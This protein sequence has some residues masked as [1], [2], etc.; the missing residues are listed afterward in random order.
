VFLRVVGV[1]HMKICTTLGRIGRT[2][3]IPANVM[4]VKMLATPLQ[5]PD[6]PWAMKLSKAALSLL[7]EGS[8][9]Y[10]ITQVKSAESSKSAARPRPRTAGRTSKLRPNR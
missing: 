3:G 4:D 7:P 2:K 9:V 8:G 6:D 5:M 1:D 10:E